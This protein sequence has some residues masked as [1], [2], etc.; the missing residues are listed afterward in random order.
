MIILENSLTAALE[1]FAHGFLGSITLK[2]IILLRIVISLSDRSYNLFYLFANGV[3]V[4]IL[5]AWIPETSILR[6]AILSEGY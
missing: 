5:I 6:I 1:R 4:S 3:K 2:P